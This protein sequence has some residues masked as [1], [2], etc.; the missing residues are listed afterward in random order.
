MADSIVT[1]K[2]LLSKL[3]E[4]SEFDFFREALVSVLRE[5]M[6]IE[7]SAKTSA[8]LGERT[9]DRLCMRN[10]YRDRCSCPG[11]NSVAILAA[12]SSSMAG[13]ASLIA[14]HND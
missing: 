4:G 8:S 10:G 6:E 7:V 3:A 14:A 1:P 5:L 12:A 11:M 2:E 13:T 9:S